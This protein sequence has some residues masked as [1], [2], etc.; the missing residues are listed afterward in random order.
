MRSAPAHTAAPV[1][2]AA[3]LARYTGGDAALKAE[4][5][6]LMCE[7]AERCI[8]LITAAPD[9]Q[10]WISALHTLKGAARGVGAFALG[11]ACEAAEA[12]PQSGWPAAAEAVAQAFAE[13]RRRFDAS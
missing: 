7:Q 10:T 5:L 12:A 3:H 8:G 4:L 9:R 11:E 1:F 2:D 6:A 13:T